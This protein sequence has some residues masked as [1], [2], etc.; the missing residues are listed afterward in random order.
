MKRGRIALPL[1]IVLVVA[2]CN[3][4][5][6]SGSHTGHASSAPQIAPEGSVDH[7]AHAMPSASPSGYAPVEI[8]PSRAAAMQLSSVTVAERDFSKQVR[9]VG[10]VGLD[11]TRSAH[12]HS[13]VRGWI[14]GI[15][16]NFVG[17]KI[18]AGEPLCSIYSQEVYAAELEFLSILDRTT[19]RGPSTG[20]FADAEKRAQAQLLEA[21]RRRLA[22]WDVPKGE[23]GRL[24]TTKQPRK[25]FPLLAPRSG[26]VVAKEAIE[27]MFVEPS[28][29]LYTLSDL[30]R[31]WVLADVYEADAPYVHV[32]DKAKLTIEGK[33]AAVEA[34]VTFLAPTIS[35]QTRT[36]KAR[37][38]L[39]NSDGS[40]R[41]GAFVNV[42]IDLPIGKALA[43][44]ESA[45]IRTGTRS[46]VFIAHGE[47]MMP[48]EVTLGPL[49]GGW[50]GVE[51][52][53]T[54][55]ERVATGAQFLLDSESR[56]RA[57]SAPGGGHVHSH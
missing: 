52:G 5:K 14:D 11:E 38:E 37:F 27:G 40:L 36:I 25:T 43:I 28:L 54:P 45:V 13:K 29:E 18:A 35:E 17:R 48:R 4:G 16:V 6:G 55:G 26:V 1:V 9:T 21:A 3:S 53:V 7:S 51:A 32:G 34:A 20:E 39:D 30:S 31:V 56:L 2:A 41:P 57:T 23:I 33:Q 10:V 42:N 49:V 22:L 44:P 47:H 46:I 24:E 50:Y 19:S 15:S 12:V 8:D